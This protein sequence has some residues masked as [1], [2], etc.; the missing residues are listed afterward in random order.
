MA[1][2]ECLRFCKRAVFLT[3]GALI[4]AVGLELFLIP[5][6]LVDGGI[7]GISIMASYLTK[8][9][10]AV[11]IVGLNIPFLI[12]GYLHI[13]KTFALSTLYSVSALAYFTTL[14]HPFP[15]FTNDILLGTVFGG[16]VLGIGVGLILR[17]GGSLDGTEITA[18]I[19]SPRF[20]FSVGEVVMFFNIFILGSAGFVFGWENAMYSLIAYFIAYKTID[21]VLEGFDESKSVM[22]IS[23]RS[24]EISEA[25]LHRLGRGVTH[26][27][28]KGGF[29]QEDK[30]VLYCVVTRLEISKLR[31]IVYDFDPEAFL[32]IEEVHDVQGGRFK[33][34]AIHGKHTKPQQVA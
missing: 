10:L 20:C 24:Q 19:I 31:N 18:L 6:K 22:I 12:L 34:K 13:G 29:T 11:F 23:D 26:F 2:K 5:N 8:L 14:L 15:A 32:A 33:K 28:A 27:Y 1:R 17:Y 7:I 16:I 3:L 4:T 30:E 21:L 25:I 9:P